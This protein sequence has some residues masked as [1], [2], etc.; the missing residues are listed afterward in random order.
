MACLLRDPGIRSEMI[1]MHPSQILRVAPS[2]LGSV[3][4]GIA[5][6]AEDVMSRF[7]EVAP[8]PEFASIMRLRL[9]SQPDD[10]FRPHFHGRVP[11]E[12]ERAACIE[13]GLRCL[14]AVRVF[15]N[16]LYR[17]EIYATAASGDSFLHLGIARLDGGTCKEWRH[18][19]RI[20][21]EIVG[22]EFEAMEIFPAESRLVDTGNQYHLWVHKDPGFRFPVGWTTRV[23]SEVPLAFDMSA[24][25]T[26][27]FKSLPSVDS[28]GA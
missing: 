6:R 21:N 1:R 10:F 24:G 27:E 23:V 26:P 4:F 15:E 8:D 13:K 2:A 3:S 11:T 28:M 12:A 25:Q 7:V 18:L 19:Q 14:T 17:V 22:P 5:N 9:Q 16:N 20:K